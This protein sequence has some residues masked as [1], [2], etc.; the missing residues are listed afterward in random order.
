MRTDRIGEVLLSTAAV[1]CIKSSYPEA[2]V[3]FVTSGY[4][5][6]VVDGRA[7]V[8]EIITANTMNSPCWLTEALRLGALLRK[9]RFDT[10][11]V[12][13]PHKTLH[14]ACFLGGIQRRIGYDRK[15]G[16]LLN[17]TVKDERDKGGK[18][19]IEYTMD[20]L[21]EMGIDAAA[22]APRLVIDKDADH[23][24]KNFLFKNGIYL[25]RPLIT[26]H[27]GS[28]NPAKIWPKDRYAE[29]IKKLDSELDCQIA[30]IGDEKE[31]ELAKEVV[32]GSGT[33]AFDFSGRF[34]LKSLAA[35]LKKSALFIGNDAGPMH[36]AAALG[37][38]VVAIFGRNIPGVGPTRWRP[39]G[40]NHVVFHEDPGCSPC[41]DTAC[42]HERRCLSAITSDAVFDAA[43]GILR[44]KI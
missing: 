36:M 35:F 21:R 40:E 30:V 15:W 23:H 17:R 42:P 9:R 38:P 7:G 20:L 41:Y 28:S 43:V 22:P 2:R 29:L 4:S 5:R 27:P 31:K 39:W 18:H 12:L 13:N 1:D 26:V 37:V 34:D 10:A 8:S 16:F 19:E 33:G 25:D 6:A 11:V 24:I 14:L 3:T 32:S 44:D